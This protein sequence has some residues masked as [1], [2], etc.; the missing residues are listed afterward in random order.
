MNNQTRVIFITLLGFII[1]I[2]VFLA[3]IK[4]TLAKVEELNKNVVTKKTELEQLKKQIITYENSQRDLSKVDGKEVI[5][6]SLLKRENLQYAIIEIEKSAELNQ[7]EESL[8]I[9]EILVVSS[10]NAPKAVISGKSFVDE[11]SYTIKTRSDFTQLITFL[12]YLEHMP[13]FTEI[14]KISLSSTAGSEDSNGVFIHEDVID[15]SID[16]V[17]FVQKNETPAN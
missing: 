1:A 14:W 17:F 6:N 3:M 11:V 8:D 13:H 2:G 16:L 7:V 12:K 15:G 10:K 9:Q 5:A 4:P